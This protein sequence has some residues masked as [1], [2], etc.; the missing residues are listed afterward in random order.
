MIGQEVAVAYAG[1]FRPSVSQHEFD[2]MMTSTETTSA[3]PDAPGG[4]PKKRWLAVLASL[5][6]PGLGQLYNGAWVKGVLLAAASL[7]ALT[8][9][10]ES[11]G[12]S[13]Q[14]L[15]TERGR[16]LLVAGE[17]ELVPPTAL[18]AAVVLQVIVLYSLWDAYR[19]AGR[20]PPAA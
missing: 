13:L 16:D 8:A 12:A 1:A 9:L 20:R 10:G 2:A 7:M 15:L 4:R 18:G 14:M 17:A 19:G 11:V 5:L 3:G 6:L